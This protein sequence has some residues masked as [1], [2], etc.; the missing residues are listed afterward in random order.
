PDLPFIR[1]DHSALRRALC[2]I[3]ENAIKFTP[4]DGRI[5]MRAERC[6]DDEVFI[7]IQD[8]GR[9]IAEEDLPRVFDKFYRGQNA[10][11]ALEASAEEVPGIG[12]GLNLAQTLVEGMNGKITVESRLEE[13]TKFT[14]RLPIWKEDFAKTRAE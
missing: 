2:A 14:A 7:E 4:N 3:A 11:G 13:G 8:D 10:G 9:G 6:R 12:L 5:T 1:A